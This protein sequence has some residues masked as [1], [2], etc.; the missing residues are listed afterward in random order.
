MIYFN[1]VST[2]PIFKPIFLSPHPWLQF[3]KCSG[4]GELFFIT[5]RNMSISS[6]SSLDAPSL[7]NTHAYL[8]PS[9]GHSKKSI[10]QLNKFKSRLKAS[11]KF[12]FEG[13]RFSQFPNL[14]WVLW[15][16]VPSIFGFWDSILETEFLKALRKYISSPYS[17]PAFSCLSLSLWDT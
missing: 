7:I 15:L 10:A 1:C 8:F 12:I 14:S 2:K 5:N 17:A 6:K 3:W 11:N 13:Y 9:H 16:K 4:N